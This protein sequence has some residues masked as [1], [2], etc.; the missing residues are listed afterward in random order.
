MDGCQHERRQP[1]DMHYEKGYCMQ[2]QPVPGHYSDVMTNQHLTFTVLSWLREFRFSSPAVISRL[3][4][5]PMP[6]N[7]NLR[8]FMRRLIDRELVETYHNVYAPKMGVLFRLGR[9][10][11]AFMELHGLPFDHTYIHPRSLESSRT[12]IHD[13]NVQ[14]VAVERMDTRRLKAKKG[15]PEGEQPEPVPPEKQIVEVSAEAHLSIGSRGLPQPDLV[16]RTTFRRVAY[17]YEMTRKS[18]ARIY[19]AFTNH[20]RAISERHYVGVCYLFPSQTLRD[21]YEE[22]YVQPLWPTTSRYTDGRVITH[23]DPFNPDE[24]HPRG[25]PRERGQKVATFTE[26]SYVSPLKG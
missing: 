2:Y 21:T 4:D 14:M 23:G 8:R 7:S 3:I 12:L 26:E 10:A 16:L 11:P 18:N 22:L 5:V 15:K 17:E 6:Y 19:F 20:L 9:L 1:S 25:N 24:L 13:L